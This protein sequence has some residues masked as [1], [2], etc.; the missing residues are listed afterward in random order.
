MTQHPGS[1]YPPPPQQPGGH[2]GPVSP[3]YGPPPQP[4]YGPPQQQY[5]PAQPQ[6]GPPQQQY[7]PPQPQ[8]GPPQQQY[9]APQPHFAPP[10]PPPSAGW[11]LERV[12]VVGGTEF[13]L[14]QLRVPPITSGLAIG[15]LI[16]GI[17]A[18]L[19]SVVAACFGIVEASEDWGAWVTGAF[20][21]LTVLAG[22][23]AIGAG[24][25]ALRQ[26]RRSG[27]TGQVRFTGRG[28]AISGIVC[29]VVA[30]GIGVLALALGLLS[31]VS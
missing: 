28:V 27:H 2:P 15:A 11:E 19:V 4:Q 29:G 9:G 21:L 25:I 16:A 22:G 31:Q 23:G 5:G 10:V 6:Y 17:G 18:I 26:I 13:G 24:M 20:T 7:G 30:A 3:Q 14:A 8:F 1:A 12:D